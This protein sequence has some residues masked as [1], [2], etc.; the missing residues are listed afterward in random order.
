MSFSGGKRE[1][2]NLLYQ[3]IICS[4]THGSSSTHSWD[5]GPGEA[6]ACQSHIVPLH[7]VVAAILQMGL[8]IKPW[9]RMALFLIASTMCRGKT[10]CGSS[11][12]C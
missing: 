9:Q 10:L 2:M 5:M 4:V 1:A 12:N 3:L 7:A 11:T 8:E 6:L